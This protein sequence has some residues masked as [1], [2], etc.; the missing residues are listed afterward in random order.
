MSNTRDSVSSGYLNTETRVENTT[1]SGVFFYEILGVWIADEVLC[2][3]VDISSHSKQ[4]RRRNGEVKRSKSRLVKTG[5]PNF[6][7][8]C[9]FV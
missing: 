1:R 6:L 9:S 4:K 8:G 7:Y 3:M 5:Y 2:L